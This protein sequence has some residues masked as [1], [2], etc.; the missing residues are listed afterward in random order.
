MQAGTLLAA[1][2]DALASR[3]GSA[4]MLHHATHALQRKINAAD[5]AASD[6]LKHCNGRALLLKSGKNG[7]KRAKV[8]QGPQC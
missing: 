4:R 3:D 5:T 8:M 7:G 1:M 6:N 2:E